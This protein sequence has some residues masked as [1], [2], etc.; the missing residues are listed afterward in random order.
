[1]LKARVSLMFNYYVP[2]SS[3]MAGGSL[4]MLISLPWLK[5]ARCVVGTAEG[6]TRHEGETSAPA[7]IGL[8]FGRNLLV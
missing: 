2:D 7:C 5:Y 1:M 8:G 3:R 4:A 6:N